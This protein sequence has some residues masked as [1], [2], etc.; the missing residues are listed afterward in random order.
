VLIYVGETLPVMI[1]NSHT[2][3]MHTK[4][5]IHG[6]QKKSKLKKGLYSHQEKKMR[7]EKISE[8]KNAVS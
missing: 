7:I 6:S 2:S 1:V 3:N 5:K 8:E 4:D